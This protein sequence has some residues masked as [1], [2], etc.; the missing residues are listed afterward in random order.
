MKVDMIFLELHSG[1][2]NLKKPRQKNSCNQINQFHEI[3]FDQI[4]FFPFQ[5]W[6]KNQFL[7]WKKV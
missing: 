4:A 6:P 1:P 5:K 3:F 2:E 7:N